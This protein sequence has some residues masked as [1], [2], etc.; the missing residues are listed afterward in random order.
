MES[1]KIAC[2]CFAGGM[3]C[4]ATAFVVNPYYWWLGIFA[5][6]MGGYV[7]YEFRKVCRALS[8]VIRTV[9]Q[10]SST[11]MKIAIP[12]AIKKAIMWFSKPHYFGYLAVFLSATIYFFGII[13]II[14]QDFKSDQTY[15]NAFIYVAFFYCTFIVTQGVVV[16]LAWAGSVFGDR[17]YWYPFLVPGG[18]CH[19]GDAEKIKSLE[20]DGLVQ[21]PLTY[22]SVVRWFLLGIVVIARFLAWTLWKE[23]ALFIWFIVSAFGATLKEV[24]ITIHSDMRILCALNGTLGGVISYVYL[25]PYVTTSVEQAMVVFFGGVLGAL[26][27]A[28]SYR[29]VT[30]KILPL[31]TNK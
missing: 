12:S 4:V 5:G 13:P 10:R 16:V 26:F 11:A 9:G 24:I 23:I 27:G 22:M 25:G 18:V 30:K 7:A 21:K 8:V 14:E 29:C 1:W 19:G 2:A 31:F 15:N 6:I 28:M 3:F 20:K 17:S